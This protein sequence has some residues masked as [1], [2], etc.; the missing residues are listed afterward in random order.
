MAHFI[1]HGSEPA[2]ATIAIACQRYGFDLIENRRRNLVAPEAMPYR[3]PCSL[4]YDSGPASAA[5][6][7]VMSGFCAVTNSISLRKSFD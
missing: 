3:N 4:G 1:S 2:G 7:P 6:K 5:V